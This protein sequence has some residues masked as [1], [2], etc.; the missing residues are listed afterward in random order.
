MEIMKDLEKIGKLFEKSVASAGVSKALKYLEEYL[1]KRKGLDLS[2]LEEILDKSL[3]DQSLLKE[4]SKLKL[5]KE[6]MELIAKS[7][8]DNARIEATKKK[9]PNDR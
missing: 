6:G 4:I 7:S 1:E 3:V 8:N 5:S 9:N 2:L